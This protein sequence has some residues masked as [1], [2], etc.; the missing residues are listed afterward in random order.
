MTGLPFAPYE[1]PE[2]YIF[3]S[4][5]HK[6]KDKVYP[7][8][9]RLH[10]MG[11]RLWY[12]KGIPPSSV[13]MA[14][15][16]EHL[17]KASYVLLFITPEAIASDYVFTEVSIARDPESNTPVCPVY[18]VETKLTPRFKGCIYILQA[19][20]RYAFDAEE[21]FYE[22]LL[23]GVPVETKQE[24]KPILKPSPEAD[25]EWATEGDNATLVRYNGTDK[26]VVI[27]ATYRGKRVIKIC[28]GS[29]SKGFVRDKTVETIHI[30]E[31]VEVL[32]SGAFTYCWALKSVTI[33]KSIKEM[34]HGIFG[35]C[36]RLN[37]VV[38]PEGIK[39]I[40]DA[41]FLECKSLTDIII[42]AS[43]TFISGNAFDYTNPALT[44]HCSKGSY[45]DKYARARG[46]KVAYTD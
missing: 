18:L 42:P 43:V 30:P 16:I 25:F 41:T 36:K 32:E 46:I 33:S 37:N 1:G 9:K 14:T 44:F 21:D 23:M 26:D 5:A 28:G 29:L 17:V 11:Y 38:L 13:W 20:Y 15:I 35:Y 39:L 3:V 19:I 12:D 22:E 4:Y 7:I 6:N 34:G 31:G 24:I 8:I 10:E 40:D 2:P 45:A 27:P